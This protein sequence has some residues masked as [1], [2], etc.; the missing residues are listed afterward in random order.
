M[1]DSV[2][3]LEDSRRN[4]C[5][6]ATRLDRACVDGVY[7]F[8]VIT[9]QM[10]FMEQ[11]RR[12]RDNHDE[13]AKQDLEDRF[14]LRKL[15]N[16]SCCDADLSGDASTQTHRLNRLFRLWQK[17][18]FHRA[19]IAHLKQDGRLALMPFVMAG[20]PDLETPEVSWRWSVVV[21]TWWNSACPTAILL[22]TGLSFKR[23]LRVH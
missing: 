12:Y 10:T 9:G 17:R 14:T 1:A 23:P 15:N 4:R 19:A 11:R 7:L 2:L 16:G 20:D 3:G 18:D 5:P 6:V 13:K 21:Q 8:R 22:L